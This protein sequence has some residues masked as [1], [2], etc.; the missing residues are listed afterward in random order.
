MPADPLQTSAL[1]EVAALTA[2]PHGW[3]PVEEVGFHAEAGT[4]S[5]LVGPAG[6][7]RSTLAAALCGSVRAVEGDVR[8][9]G[10]SLAGRPMHQRVAA[11]LIRVPAGGEQL[12]GYSL[13]EA[14]ALSFVLAR[15]PAWSMLRG[16]WKAAGPP[17]RR[18]VSRLL[19]RTGL[20]SLADHPVADLPLAS[21]RRLQLAQALAGRPRLLIID[22]PWHGLLQQEREAHAALLRS[23]CD[24]HMAVL[25]VEDDLG[26]VA[27][28]AD[29]VLV[30]HRGRLA[31]QGSAAEIAASASVR[32]IFAGAAAAWA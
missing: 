31:A 11:G 14:I 9:G 16:P 29:Q 6:A 7:G 8:L 32:G 4:I 25:L 2:R 20:A 28:L 24:D 27:E 18:E 1:L 3:P 13:F 21:R 30:L 26:L 17:G 12:P 15:R 23:L 19:E 22:R 10:W 5:A